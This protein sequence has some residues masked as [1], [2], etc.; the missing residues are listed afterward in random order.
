MGVFMTRALLTG[1][2]QGVP[3]CVRFYSLVADRYSTF[4]VSEKCKCKFESPEA[5]RVHTHVLRFMMH[6]ESVAVPPL[7]KWKKCQGK[8]VSFTC[9]CWNESPKYC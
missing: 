9:T 8:L 7:H 5:S 3:E 4:Q 2:P 6:V 1:I